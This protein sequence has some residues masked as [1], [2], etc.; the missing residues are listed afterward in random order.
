MYPTIY[1][2]TEFLDDFSDLSNNLKNY[3][4]LDDDSIYEEQLTS[5]WRIRDLILTSNVV[6]NITNKQTV[7][8]IKKPSTGV[9]KSYKDLILHQIINKSLNC[10]KRKFEINVKEQDCKKNNICYFTN[11][12]KDEAILEGK[13]LGIII[14]G[15][16]VINENFYLKIILPNLD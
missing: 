9:F 7:N 1:V 13:Q 10:S 5:F 2:S 8:Y 16:N 14:K 11:K 15:K 12:N 6:C 4:I 3:N